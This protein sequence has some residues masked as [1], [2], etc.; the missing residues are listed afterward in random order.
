MPNKRLILHHKSVPLR[1]SSDSPAK[2]EIVLPRKTKAHPT[3]SP[4]THRGISSSVIFLLNTVCPLCSESF[5]PSFLSLPLYLLALPS[6]HSC[7]L[8]P[9]ISYVYKTG[10]PGPR[11]L[12]CRVDF[13]LCTVHSPGRFSRCPPLFEVFSDTSDSQ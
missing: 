4:L 10:S 12:C 6:L 9:L 13:Q 8:Y 5:N 1:W 7:E 3:S 2:P 11:L